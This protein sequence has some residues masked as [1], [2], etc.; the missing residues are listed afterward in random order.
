M[1]ES[2]LAAFDGHLK[3][4]LKLQSLLCSDLG[5]HLPL[6]ISLSRPMVLLNEQRQPFQDMMEA[7]IIQ[8][9]VRP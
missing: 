6:H 5:A 1:L 4:H 9:G 2:V 8:S 7:E 3:S